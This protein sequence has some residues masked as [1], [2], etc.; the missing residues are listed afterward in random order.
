MN[1]LLRSPYYITLFVCF[2]Y[3]LQTSW[4]II[5]PHCTDKF[6]ECKKLVNLCNDNGT[7]GNNMKLYCTATCNFCPLDKCF[8]NN[9]GWRTTMSWDEKI[10]YCTAMSDSNSMLTTGPASGTCGY[11]STMASS[12]PGT[13]WKNMR[14]Y[15]GLRSRKGRWPWMVQLISTPENLEPGICGGSLLSKKWVVTAAHCFRNKYSYPI[16][17]WTAILGTSQNFL[18]MRLLS[19]GLEIRM[20]EEVI[21]H[22]E[23]NLFY[24]HDIALVKLES[25]VNYSDVIKPICLPCLETPQEGD[26]CW[27]V[28]Y[29]KTDD[30]KDSGA[31]REVDVPIASMKSC[32]KV[33][34]DSGRILQQDHMICAGHKE[35]EKDACNGDS[36]GPLMCQR[37]D[38]CQWYQAGI[39][40]F[41]KGGCGLKG[42]YGV[43]TSMKAHQR[44]IRRHIGEEATNDI[45][46]EKA[47]QNLS[48]NDTKCSSMME[49]C[50]KFPDYMKTNCAATC[51]RLK[52]G[53]RPSQCQDE[54]TF[55]STCRKNI[56][57]CSSSIFSSFMKKHCKRTCG[58]C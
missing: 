52:Y 48:D 33:Y 21:I 14:I 37:R 46:P 13:H 24:H 57:H 19:D 23:H 1:L 27:T 38:S 18:N 56:K 30:D 51:C 41:G 15:G 34:A 55:Q 22:P 20:L 29:G 39:V 47:C 8:E 3:L 45:C 12:N 7:A 42:V 31:L 6:S 2:M 44:W 9:G 26:M 49:R 40:S 43:Y 58:I 16:N 5:S 25:Q 36:G 11:D 28:G 4:A 54:P 35:G 53:T 17:T 50:T 10:N 32:S